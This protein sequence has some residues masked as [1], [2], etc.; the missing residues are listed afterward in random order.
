MPTKLGFKRPK[1][2][3]GDGSNQYRQGRLLGEPG[4]QLVQRAVASAGCNSASSG[5]RYFS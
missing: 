3:G 4:L 2:V 5:P 1:Y